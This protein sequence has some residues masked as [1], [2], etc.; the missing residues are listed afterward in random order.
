M[1]GHHSFASHFPS[2]L[3]LVTREH[4]RNHGGQPYSRNQCTIESRSV[5]DYNLKYSEH[6][7]DD[8]SNGSMRE[9]RK[10]HNSVVEQMLHKAN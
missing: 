4:L 9:N 7:C 2:S 10:Y 3:V 6:L 8:R 5:D 1:L